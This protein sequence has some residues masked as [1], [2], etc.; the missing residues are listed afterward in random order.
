MQ[1]FCSP[2]KQKSSLN[3]CWMANIVRRYVS[4]S[5][6]R[7]TTATAKQSSHMFSFLQW[8][9]FFKCTLTW[10]PKVCLHWELK[11]T[12]RSGEKRSRHPTHW[13]TNTAN[14]T[15]KALN[16]T[17]DHVG[18]TGLPVSPVFSFLVTRNKELLWLNSTH[19]LHISSPSC[20]AVPSPK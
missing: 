20:E 16:C 6:Y 11:C 1:S 4:L 8:N 18:W 12:G 9:C 14:L 13:A 2:S 5:A 19:A 10:K 15:E 7:Y 17:S 3:S